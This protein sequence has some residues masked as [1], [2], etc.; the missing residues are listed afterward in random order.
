MAQIVADQL[1]LEPTDIL[2]NTEHDTQKDPWSI[3]AGTYSCRFTPGT[4]VATH[5][6]AVQV[7]EKLARIA[8]QSLNV[9]AEEVEF[10]GGRIFARDNPENALSFHRVAGSAHWSPGG[11]PEGMDGGLRE[12]GTWDP[13]E[14]TPPDEADRI[15]TSLAYGFVFDFCGIELDPDT[16]AVRIDEYVTMHDSGKRLNPLIVDGQIHG[17]F[18]QGLGAALLESFEYDDDGNFLTGTFADYLL[19]T[20]DTVPTP[21]VMHMESPSPFTPLGAKGVGEGN[22]MSTPVCLANAVCDALGIDHIDLPLG[23]AKLAEHLFGDETPR[24]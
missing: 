6:A 13:P 15:N 16:G 17:A 12:T 21:T 24:P 7:R 3:A 22:C 4:A 10:A 9:P 18:G 19:P 2:V 14:L 8:A 23:P 11:L 1:G 5:K 20:A